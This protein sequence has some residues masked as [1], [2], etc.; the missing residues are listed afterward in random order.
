[1]ESRTLIDMIEKEMLNNKDV[2]IA[3]FYGKPGI[4]IIPKNYPEIKY[5]AVWPEQSFGADGKKYFLINLSFPITLQNVSRIFE[6]LTNNIINKL[7]EA[8]NE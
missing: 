5:E 6:N 1:M 3:K 2:N 7:M 8:K 4:S